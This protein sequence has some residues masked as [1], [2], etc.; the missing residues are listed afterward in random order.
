[1][2]VNVAGGAPVENVVGKVG[3]VRS[4][5]VEGA[6]LSCGRRLNPPRRGDATCADAR[7]GC[8]R[9]RNSSQ[10]HVAPAVDEAP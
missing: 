2:C 3:T 5:A 10:R 7:S 9:K 1:M 8:G 6:G 4:V